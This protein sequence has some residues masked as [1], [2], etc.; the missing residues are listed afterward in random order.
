TAHLLVVFTGCP[1]ESVSG[2]HRFSRADY[3]MMTHPAWSRKRQQRQSRASMA[4]ALPPVCG[5]R[6]KR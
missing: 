1:A 5:N 3:G 6:M 2:R 4:F